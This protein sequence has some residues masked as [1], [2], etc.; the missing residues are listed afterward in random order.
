MNFGDLSKSFFS[1]LAIMAIIQTFTLEMEDEPLIPDKYHKLYY[2]FFI[3]LFLSYIGFSFLEGKTEFALGL[4]LSLTLWI[5]Y[6]FKRYHYIRVYECENDI[7][8]NFKDSKYVVFFIVLWII[9]WLGTLV[10]WKDYSYFM[11]IR[12][13]SCFLFLMCLELAFNTSK[14]L[15]LCF[16]CLMIIFNPIIPLT[17]TKEIWHF[18]DAIVLIFL[19]LFYL[20]LKKLERPNGKSVKL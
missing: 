18:L 15:F 5:W 11:M 12:Y 19:C 16:L 14:Y 2:T 3:L 13:V 10:D 7:T 4:T 17:L 8:Y 9:I 20:K 6:I 1:G